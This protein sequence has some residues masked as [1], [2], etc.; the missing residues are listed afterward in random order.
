[1]GGEIAIEGVPRVMDT[2][3][4]FHESVSYALPGFSGL[5]DVMLERV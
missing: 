1:M 4:E 2:V 5:L 3:A